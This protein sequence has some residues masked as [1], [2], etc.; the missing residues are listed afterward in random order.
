[1]KMRVAIFSTAM[2]V[3]MQ[4]STAAYAWNI[5]ED[6]GTWDL[7]RCADGSNSTVGQTD[8][9]WTVLTAGNNGKTGG[10]FAIAGQAALYGC[11]E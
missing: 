10:Q 1:M 8:G 3:S 4:A 2:A 7:I 6:H 11:G 5:Q 9:G